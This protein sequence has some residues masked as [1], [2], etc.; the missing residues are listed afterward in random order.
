MSLNPSRHVSQS[1]SI[2]ISRNLYVSKGEEVV[3]NEG[4]ESERD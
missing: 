2:A 1:L 4:V 3:D